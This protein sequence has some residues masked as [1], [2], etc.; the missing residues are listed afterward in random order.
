MLVVALWSE[1]VFAREKLD[2]TLMGGFGFSKTGGEAYQVGVSLPVS[3]PVLKEVTVNW[4]RF[5]NKDMISAAYVY[6]IGPVGLGAGLAYVPE[7]TDN[8][9]RKENGYLE[10]S[11]TPFKP[12]ICKWAHVSGISISDKGENMVMCGVR[13]FL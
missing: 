1:D 9:K 3:I 13:F 6:N 10:I 11:L 8:L 5:S 2:L 7:I 4:T 12:M